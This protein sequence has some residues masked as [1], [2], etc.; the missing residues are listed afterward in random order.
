MDG[1]GI[2]EEEYRNEYNAEPGT[3]EAPGLP[4]VEGIEHRIFRM[5][6]PENNDGKHYVRFR[7]GAGQLKLVDSY[8]SRYQREQGFE[9]TETPMER[10]EVDEYA[11]LQQVIDETNKLERKP[12]SSVIRVNYF[13][14]FECF[15]LKRFPNTEFGQFLNQ[16]KDPSAARVHIRFVKPHKS[17]VLAFIYHM[18]DKRKNKYNSIRCFLSA[19][20]MT[21]LDCGGGTFENGHRIDKVMEDLKLEDEERR[22]PSFHPEEMLPKLWTTIWEK[23]SMSYEK[24]VFLWT[25]ILVQLSTIARA[26]DI[27]YEKNRQYCPLV[28]DM[29]FPKVERY[30]RPDG[31]PMFI[32]LVWRDWK[33]R[34]GKK[35]KTPYRVRLC[36]NPLNAIYCPVFWL[37]KT[38]DI[39]K[40][41]DPNKWKDGPILPS[42]GSKTYQKHLKKLFQLAGVPQYSSHSFRRSGAQWAARCGVE[43][44]DI[45]DIGRWMSYTN[46]EKYVAEGRRYNEERMNESGCDEDPII[47]FWMYNRMAK[48][49]S[50]VMSSTQLNRSM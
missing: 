25:R 28:S 22:A 50:M 9:Q 5:L 32:T 1:V 17:T 16:I 27:S 35:E 44:A 46:L 49:D 21:S 36:A 37:L 42:I 34:S 47:Y 3:D 6:D 24:K 4:P 2:A 26:S 48:L 38:L 23:M 8:V 11:E 29:E 10:L 14:Y 31:L 7:E 13:S 45:K 43:M 30:Y 20:S 19:L 15:V 39:M 12:N 18:R 33:G 41:K 40:K